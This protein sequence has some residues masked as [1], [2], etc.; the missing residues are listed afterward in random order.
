MRDDIPNWNK[1]LNYHE[2]RILLLAACDLKEEDRTRFTRQNRESHPIYIAEG[3]K[4]LVKT[5]KFLAPDGAG[6]LRATQ[7]GVEFLRTHTY[8]KDIR[9]IQ[10]QVVIE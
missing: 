7:S 1:V 4:K 9:G 2:M 3:T 8:R 10:N 5:L 6:G